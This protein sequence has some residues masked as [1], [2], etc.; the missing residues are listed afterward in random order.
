MSLCVCVTDFVRETNQE[1]K[2]ARTN[3][4]EKS[5]LKAKLFVQ[6]S[7]SSRRKLTSESFAPA[8]QPARASRSH[9]DVSL[10]MP[11]FPPEPVCVWA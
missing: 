6:G 7:L 8:H 2:N 1:K 5:G 9:G 3:R 11:T 4:E 10:Q